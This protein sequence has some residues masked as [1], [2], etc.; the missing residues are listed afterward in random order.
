MYI[1]DLNEYKAIPAGYKQIFQN[2][3]SNSISNNE[4]IKRKA[5]GVFNDRDLEVVKFL[6]K[7]K[8]ATLQ[9][10]YDYLTVTDNLGVN[11]ENI[12]VSIYSIKSRLEKLVQNRVLNKFMLAED[13][14]ISLK[15][16]ALYFYCL[17]LGGKFLLTNYS[18]EDTSDW[19][20]RGNLKASELISKDIFTTQ[21]Y[22]SL[23][24]SCGHKVVYFY[25]YPIRTC[26]KLT[27]IPTFEFAVNH[28]GVIK[29]FI[30]EVVRA[31][32]LPVQFDSKLTKLSKFV[33]GNYWKKY[34]LKTEESPVVFAFAENNEVVEDVAKMLSYF[35]PKFRLSTDERIKGELA[36]S[37]MSYDNNSLVTVKSSILTK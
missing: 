32:D 22:I 8:F 5:E 28:N 20:V 12:E 17:D 21:F 18:N 4:V 23:L 26:D 24:N 36:T 11:N 35:I 1:K 13:V 6:F 15:E 37:F 10:I 29:Y 14:D 19:Y 30:G 2:K 16:D 33:N 31:N 25:T 9:Q 34:Y 7:F 3:F 27:Y